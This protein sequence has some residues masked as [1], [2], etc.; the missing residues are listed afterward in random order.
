MDNTLI[1]G[2]EY[3]YRVQGSNTAGLGLFCKPTLPT[4]A[5]DPCDAPSLPIVTDVTDT[6]VELKWNPPRNTGGSPIAGYI[7][8]KRKFDQDLWNTA[9]SLR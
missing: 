8:E 1:E 7:I 3:Q 2:L 5:R 4:A 6:T 9:V